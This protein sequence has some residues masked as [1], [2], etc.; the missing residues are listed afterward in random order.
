MALDS[1]RRH[2]SALSAT[3][4]IVRVLGGLV[5]LL[6]LLFAY[7]ALRAGLALRE[8]E[9]Q[10]QLL[11]QQLND[12]DQRGATRS[13]R[14]IAAAGRTARSHT[15]NL[16]WD[17]A[18]HLPLLG[19]DVHAVQVISR[20]LDDTSRAGLPSALRL[21]AALSQQ[22]LR[23]A[24][25]RLDVARIAALAPEFDRMDDA[26]DRASRSLS[27]LGSS[28]LTSSLRGSVTTLEEQLRS[29]R[30][31]AKAGGTAA[32]V[33][34]SMLGQDGPRTYLLVVQNN[35]EIRATGGLPGS[36]S[37]LTADDGKLTL[38]AQRSS[39]DLPILTTPVVPLTA[40][41]LDLY[42]PS[43]GEDIRDANLTPDFPRAA[44]IMS[45]M[46]ER[47]YGQ[48]LDGVISVDPVA[49]RGVLAAIGPIVVDGATF[50]KDNVVANLLN[51]PY[52]RL[53]TEKAQDD[54]FAGAARGIFDALLTKKIDQPAVVR[55][56]AGAGSQQHL[57][58]WSQHA[59]E[60]KRL[61]GAA[62]SGALARKGAAP[63]VGMYLNDATAAKMEYYLDYSSSLSSVSCDRSGRQTLNA[64]LVL[65]STAPRD[66]SGLSRWV[67][68]TGKFA[69]KGS[70]R[71]N[72]RIYPP[73][74]GAVTQIEA[75]GVPVVVDSVT[76]AGRQVAVV[77]LVVKP[78]EQ[79]RLLATLT[80]ATGQRADPVLRVTP[81][82]RT[83]D[84][85]GTAPSSCR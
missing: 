67:T 70:I 43:M 21:S 26:V 73:V 7:Q 41:E 29:L 79:I 1:L 18:S 5:L 82:V 76:H 84:S 83:T 4:L 52:Q 23:S 78:G 75:N 22:K 61:Q 64:G 28:S 71:M 14:E 85:G 19:D 37:T 57:L 80:G 27:P 45:T 17:A 59:G 34:P 3:Q 32:R 54:Y 8:A 63:Q 50:D 36:F 72:L 74:N 6:V 13:L 55:Q 69:A 56:L 48:S 9:T 15:G 38:G 53:D 66:L 40:E 42:G 31:L 58:V 2:V 65:T 20:V 60:Q 24:D 39:Q 11:K 47:R 44:S 10:A 81:G 51:L 33:L 49:L 16:M 46:L 12:G 62:V 25:G 77:G 30:S 35:A 68:G